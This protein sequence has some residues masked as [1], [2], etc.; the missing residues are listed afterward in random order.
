MK[1]ISSIKSK[2]NIDWFVLVMGCFSI[3]FMYTVIGMFLQYTEINRDCEAVNA[4]LEAARTMNNNLRE[5]KNGLS[6]VNY[7]EKIAREELG[8]TKR[9]E[10]PFISAQK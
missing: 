10:M 9:G 6:D 5:E 7:I 2:R 3:Y 1:E 4:R 8:M